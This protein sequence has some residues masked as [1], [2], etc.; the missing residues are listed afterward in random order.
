[1]YDYDSNMIL[2]KPLP[3]RQANTIKKAWEEMY[4]RLTKHGHVIS[5]F[6]LDNE[7]SYELKRTFIKYNINFQK[8]PPHMH[9]R[10]A[11]ERAIQT[12]KS[13][14]LSGLAT[15]HSEF[16]ISEWDRLLDQA[17]ITLNLLR[18][19][20]VNP[21]LSAWSY[22]EG[23]Y[24]FNAW[25]IAPPGSKVV[26]H[27]KKE[28]RASFEYKGKEGWYVGPT[29]EHYRC[30]KCYIPQSH[31][32]IIADTVEFVPEKIPFPTVTTDFLLQ[33]TT[34][35]LVALLTKRKGIGL[36]QVEI[37]DKTSNALVRIAETLKRTVPI[38]KLPVKTLLEAEG[39]LASSKR[40]G[41]SNLQRV[42]SKL[43]EE[44]T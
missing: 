22:I 1:M 5:N 44:N 36:P 26:V 18:T 14:L 37:G 38:P 24:D 41:G 16:P 27:K 34:T 29:R 28:Q 17:E 2:C 7:L 10:N 4:T 3:N 11:A 23:P 40:I 13:H 25:P 42:Q 30:I 35:D 6:I 39:N 19:S 8:V 32:E 15:C 12:F 33:Q 31:S 21:N 20:R 9:R 43:T